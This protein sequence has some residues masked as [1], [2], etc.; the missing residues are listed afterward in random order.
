VDLS[1]G[2]KLPFGD[3]A[4]ADNTAI[5]PLLRRRV[6]KIIAVVAAIKS[7]MD[8][9]AEQWAGNQW[10]T[11]GRQAASFAAALSATYSSARPQ[12]GPLLILYTC[13]PCPSLAAAVALQLATQLSSHTSLMCAVCVCVCCAAL[14]GVCPPGHGRNFE[15]FA[16][17]YE[18][19]DVFN[20]RAKVGAASRLVCILQYGRSFTDMRFP[21]RG[22]SSTWTAITAFVGRMSATERKCFTRHVVCCMQGSCCSLCP[23]FIYASYGCIAALSALLL[24]VFPSEGFQELYAAVKR[25]VAAGGP[26]H[27][28]ATYTVQENVYEGIPGG[29]QVCVHCEAL[30]SMIF[31]NANVISNSR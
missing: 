18:A 27:H 16:E 17:S 1:G 22:E 11:S 14:F 9:T 19:V 12:S 21:H 23:Y 24:Q 3:G 7:V 30:L 5:T 10:E 20:K 29:W 8:M 6:P 15:R 2:A 4:G 31:L 26:A 25:S 13:L 28:L